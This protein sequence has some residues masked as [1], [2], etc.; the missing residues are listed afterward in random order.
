MGGIAAGWLQNEVERPLD[1]GVGGDLRAGLREPADHQS[2]GLDAAT[3]QLAQDV[4]AVE[5]GHFHVERHEVRFRLDDVFDRRS[6]VG[7]AAHD[8]AIR[9]LRQHISQH[10]AEQSR[11]V[12][13]QDAQWGHVQAS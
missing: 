7:G 3:F 12:D 6:A 1:E 8:L 4:D 2:L 11:I 9:N 10:R 13:H 5:I